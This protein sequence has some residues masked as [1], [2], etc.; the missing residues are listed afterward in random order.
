MAEQRSPAESSATQTA[1]L[2]PPLMNAPRD[3]RRGG[4][5]AGGGSRPAPDFIRPLT[6]PSSSSNPT[7]VQRGGGRVGRADTC[8][9]AALK[10][11]SSKPRP[12]PPPPGSLKSLITLAQVENRARSRSV[13]I[14]PRTR[15]SEWRRRGRLT[16][17]GARRAASAHR[18]ESSLACFVLGFAI[19]RQTGHHCLCLDS[20]ICPSTQAKRDLSTFMA[21]AVNRGVSSSAY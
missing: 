12:I 8:S 21:L 4:L 2:A 16:M 3:G 18:R 11:A 14:R 17:A 5:E 20:F 15:A 1:A 10:R 19:F 6:S 9:P 13:S 7:Q